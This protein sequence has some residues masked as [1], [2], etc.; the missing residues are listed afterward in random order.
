MKLIIIST[1]LVAFTF[2]ECGAVA[3]KQ[4]PPPPASQKK[5]VHKKKI[6]KLS[7]KGTA[8]LQKKAEQNAKRHQVEM[9]RREFQIMQESQRRGMMQ[10]QQML[11]QKN[12]PQ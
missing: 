1:L 4:L 10:Q 12:K 6:R 9:Q 3:G 8:N 5:T 11:Q 7:R 2:G